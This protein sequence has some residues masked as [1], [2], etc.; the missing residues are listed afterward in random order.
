MR[1]IEDRQG[2]NGQRNLIRLVAGVDI[3]SLGDEELTDRDVTFRGGIVAVVVV[4]QERSASQ[5]QGKK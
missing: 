5:I 1:N 4:G 3:C 2:N